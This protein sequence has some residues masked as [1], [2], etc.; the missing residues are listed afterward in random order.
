M[1]PLQPRNTHP[2]RSGPGAIAG[3]PRVTASRQS[4]HRRP[5]QPSAR[6]VFHGYV[7]HSLRKLLFQTIVQRPFEPEHYYF[8]AMRP[9]RPFSI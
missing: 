2:G 1:G 8:D 4:D 7:S 6:V 3:T 5:A 9:P